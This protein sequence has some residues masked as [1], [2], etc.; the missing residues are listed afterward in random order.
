MEKLIQTGS[1]KTPSINFDPDQG[2]IEIKGKSIPEN[3]A[4]FYQPLYDWL[5]RYAQNPKEKTFVNLYMEYFNTSSS[6]E[7]FRFFRKLEA[8][9]SSGVTTMVVDWYYEED[10]EE[11]MEMGLSLEQRLAVPVRVKSFED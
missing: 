11:M 10:D 4:E 5:D 9:H 8:M 6:K 7:F 1:L 2:L 3:A